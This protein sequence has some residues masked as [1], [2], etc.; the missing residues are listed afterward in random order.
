MTTTIK[1][2]KRQFNQETRQFFIAAPQPKVA[3]EEERPAVIQEVRRQLRAVMEA[4]FPSMGEK[5]KGVRL[6]RSGMHEFA[7][8]V[9]GRAWIGMT[10]SPAEL[11]SRS[12]KAYSDRKWDEP[13]RHERRELLPM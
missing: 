9:N 4:D 1:G 12:I 11:K 6:R 3:T 8:I 2:L 7:Y 13:A 5:T 10:F